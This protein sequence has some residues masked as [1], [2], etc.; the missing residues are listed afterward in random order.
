MQHRLAGHDGRLAAQLAFLAVGIY[1]S[2]AS[3]GCREQANLTPDWVSTQLRNGWRL[4]PITLGPQASCHPNFP[5][6]GNDPR[7]SPDPTDSYAKARAQGRLEANRAVAAAQALG[8]VPGSTLWY[9]L[10][11]TTGLLTGHCRESALRFMHAWTNRLHTLNYVS[12]FYSSAGSGIK[13]MDDARVNR[14][15]IFSLPDY[16]WVA[17]WDGVAN[18]SVETK[19]LRTDGWTPHRRVKQYMGGHD[20]TWGG[21]TVNID[22]DFLDVGRGSVAAAETHC[23]G[24][25]VN[26]PQYTPSAAQARR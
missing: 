25:R 8:I 3:R 18:T 22:R 26:F 20:E 9:D 16:L 10:E 11:G 1:I 19:Y 21:V 7:I 6:Y 14:P 15:G 12:G 4:L 2:G 5:R 17:R 23:N 24:I 13:I